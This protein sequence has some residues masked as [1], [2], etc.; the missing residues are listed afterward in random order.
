[1]RTS[2]SAVLASVMIS[3][4]LAAC[5]P[6]SS[7]ETDLEPPR[8]LWT[9]RDGHD[10]DLSP[11]ERIELRFS[12]PL[13]PETVNASTIVVV[14][15]ELGDPCSVD[16]AC[17]EGRCYHGRCQRDPVNETWLEDLGHP[18]LSPTRLIQGT[19]TAVSLDGGGAVVTVEPLEAL[20]PFR[21]HDLLVSSAVSDLSGNPLESEMGPAESIRL[22]FATGGPELAR[23]SVQLLS[24]PA[25][26]ADVATN[27]RR[28]VV[29]FSKPVYGVHSGSLWLQLHSGQRLAGEVIRASPLCQ[30][31]SAGT[32]YELRLAERLPPLQQIEL[33]TSDAVMD[34][35]GRR[36]LQG[37][38]RL[39]ATSADPDLTAPEI[40]ALQVQA[41]DGCVVVRVRSS[42]PVDVALRADWAAQQPASTGLAEAELSLQAPV[43]P[44]AE[45]RIVLQ[46][47]AGNETVSAPQ[48]V[49]P[50]D[51]AAR[52][53]ITEV[54]A[55][56]AGPEPSQ[57]WVEL[58]NL[59]DAPVNLSAWILDD[60]DDGVGR[61]T[62]PA[63]ELGP[64]QHA[65]V[66]GPK[67]SENN[68]ADPSPAAGTLLL[69]LQST[70]G[71]GGLANAGEP[72]VLR[73]PRGQLISAYGAHYATAAKSWS[74]RS[75]ERIN[76][77]G[78]DV[79]A[80]WRPN[81]DG[82]STPGLA[83]K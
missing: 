34:A 49:A 63:S 77:A 38:P 57:E 66:V 45:L 69:R 16:L 46:D 17:P 65:V 6:S 32:C 72:I 20:E 37:A 81:P 21:W 28:A 14:P 4:A 70:L 82:R 43:S 56:P 2:R 36:V 15:F 12:E 33:R 51:A 9:S 53:V 24:P 40:G 5:R 60:N 30:E 35:E 80:N 54:L 44:G 42:E 27:L 79:R 78:C 22:Q 50:F 74:G 61:N 10:R 47:L 13:D 55:N 18:P 67:Y 39:F 83:A 59:S 76:P 62:L 23:P 68:P 48:V 64:G 41:A 29:S 31:R 11:T 71:A 75:V 1:M 25:R 7:I 8:L 58:Q 3:S 26:S 73:D 19:L 52:V